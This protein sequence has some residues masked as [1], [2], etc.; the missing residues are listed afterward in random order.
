MALSRLKRLERR[1][2][3]LAGLALI[4]G[5][6]LI[7]RAPES[8]AIKEE[9]YARVFPDFDV[10]RAQR[11]RIE[12][13]GADAPEVLELA[14]MDGQRWT[15]ASHADHP[16]P[17]GREM[18]VL[19]AMRKL[20]TKGL[21][22]T[23]SETFDQYADTKG[24]TRIT[25]LDV[26]GT[27]MAEVDLGRVT[28]AWPERFIRV[29]EGE[30]ARVLRALGLDGGGIEPDVATWIEPRLF[31]TLSADDV[32]RIDI[33]QPAHGRT[34]TLVRRGADPIDVELENVPPVDPE[35]PDK[36]WWLASPPEQAG[37]AETDRVENLIRSF[38]GARVSDIAGG[39][40][41]AEERERY[42]LDAPD[43]VVTARVRTG[44]TLARHELTLGAPTDASDTRYA[45]RGGSSF[46]YALKDYTLAPFRKA[47][48][49]FLPEEE[50]PPEAPGPGPLMG[51][52][53]ID[54]PDEGAEGEGDAPPALPPVAPPPI[55]VPPEDPDSPGGG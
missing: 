53:G 19:D 32:V 40:A 28:D 9:S 21:V 31:P 39:H 35:D 26:Q 49:E 41:S 8:Q 33:R 50:A 52:D 5:A 29:G 14:R 44:N 20:R 51:P 36:V 55:P 23:R 18:R 7:F 34:I 25:V 16:V 27:S 24:W 15:L 1:N 2:Y 38:T 47:P 13:L 6:I 3:G 11:I 12:V 22:T 17:D 48:D 42:G 45:Q 4:L 37:D 46:V 30:D 43:A 10:E 54:A